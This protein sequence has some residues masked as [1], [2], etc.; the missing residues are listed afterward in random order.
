MFIR[1]HLLSV[2]LL[3]ISACGRKDLW[4]R[5][6]TNIQCLQVDVVE[7]YKADA[8]RTDCDGGVRQELERLHE[9]LTDE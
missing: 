3:F 8:L 4:T 5:L 1:S 7:I 9:W 6:N 2:L